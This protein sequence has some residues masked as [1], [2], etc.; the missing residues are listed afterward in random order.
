MTRPAGATLAH[1]IYPNAPLQL[2][3]VE[4]SYP[5]TEQQ[6][7]PQL[8]SAVQAVL[9]EATT[10]VG[11]QVSGRHPRARP[12]Q[13]SDQSLVPI[14]RHLTFIAPRR[15]TSVARQCGAGVVSA[16]RNRGKWCGGRR[17]EVAARS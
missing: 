12:A 5:A 2:V 10:E 4:V 15:G 7:D 14:H 8:F 13:P 1:E 6:F 11:G 17:A 16:F 3:A 9:G